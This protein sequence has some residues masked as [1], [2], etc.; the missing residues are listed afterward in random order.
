MKSGN[1][2]SNHSLF[3]GKTKSCDFIMLFVEVIQM[4]LIQI[5][6][7]IAELRKEQKL[8]QEQFGEKVGVTN[9]TVSRWENGNYLPPADILLTISQ[10]FDIL[11]DEKRK[12]FRMSCKCM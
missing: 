7:F 3:V 10:M 4:D 8:T 11:Y 1:A 2:M 9:K 6:K 12:R 5:G